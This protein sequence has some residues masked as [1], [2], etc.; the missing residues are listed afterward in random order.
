MANSVPKAVPSAVAPTAQN[1]VNYLTGPQAGPLNASTNNSYAP[2]VPGGP[3]EKVTPNP[4]MGS[5]PCTTGM[6]RESGSSGAPTVPDM[7]GVL[8]RKGPVDSH[9]QSEFQGDTDP[10]HKVNN[11]P[12]RGMF[13]FVKGYINGIFTSQDK[14]NAGWHVRHPQ[15]RTSWMRVTPPPHGAGYAPEI[16][17]PKQQPQN[18]NTYKYMPSTGTQPYGSGTPRPT[19]GGYQHGRVLN[20][21]TFGAGQTAGGIG[22]NQYTPTPGPPE[23]NSTAGNYT[24]NT[25]MPS[26]G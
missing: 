15:Q 11:P 23:T 26:W 22:G 7:N 24:D 18:P 25:G 2:K 19:G 16:Y 6:E 21:D 1:S 5:A 3:T 10:Y 20:S 12:T 9:Y 17:E 8:F 4:T 13:T 14:D